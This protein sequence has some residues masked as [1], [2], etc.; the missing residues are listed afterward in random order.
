MISVIAQHHRSQPFAGGTHRLVHP[1]AQL[2]LNHLETRSH[3][4]GHGAPRHLELSVLAS[5]TYVRQSQKIERF[6]WSPALDLS[7]SVRQ[8][9]RT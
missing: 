6:G 2:Q 1:L 3:S 8:T 5:S 9:G 7:D 4:L